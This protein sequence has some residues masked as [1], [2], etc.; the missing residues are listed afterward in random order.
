M[1]NVLQDFLV[2]LGFKID[3]AAQKKM[4]TALETLQK[5]AAEATI[6]LERMAV[7]LATSVVA[8]EVFTGL[9]RMAR[10]F[11]DLAYSAKRTGSS[12]GDV[13]AFAYAVSQLGGT[14][15]GAM[16]SM[17]GLARRVRENPGYAA[18]LKNLGVSDP[19]NTERS[20][21]ELGRKFADLQK[22]GEYF[23]AAQYAND[24]GFDEQTL[25]AM[26]AG[27][28]QMADE[29]RAKMKAAGLDPEKAKEDGQKL[30]QVF[31]SMF[32]SID[33]IFESAGSKIFEKLGGP[34]KD[35]TAFLD[36]NGGRISEVIVKI[37]EAILGLV[38]HISKFIASDE[39][40]KFVDALTDPEKWDGFLKKLTLVGDMF[41]KILTVLS[42]ISE[43][44]SW[45]KQAEEWVR[46]RAWGPGGLTSLP[47]GY[48]AGDGVH[49]SLAGRVWNR[50]K[51]A[52]NWAT[53]GGGGEASGGRAGKA[54]KSANAAAVMD[55]LK[56]A[57]LP[58]EG[59]AAAMGSAQSESAFNPRA[60]NSVSGGHDGLIQWDST[61]WPKVAAWIKSQGGDPFDA[62]W[63]ARAFVAEG[64]AKPGDPLYDGRATARG[65]A[66]LENSA[67]HL[68]MAVL[69]MGLI[70][71]F[72]PREEGGRAANARAWLPHVTAPAA[73]P[74]SP[75]PGLASG[76]PGDADW[77][78]HRGGNVPIPKM[79]ILPPAWAG[80][81]D[82][83]SI[84]QGFAPL[85]VGGSPPANN[86]TTAHQ[87]VSITVHGSTDPDK[88]GEMIGSHVKRANG[89]LL[90]TM[91]SP[92][93]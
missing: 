40:K 5:R 27:V 41:D 15:Q 57:G 81:F 4:H 42:K 54:S 55:E 8:K 90:S 91:Q 32:T 6:A 10:G 88:T 23:R 24:L 84:R 75:S 30:S 70:E 13:R 56:K 28:G 34:L 64:R 60:H 50:A 18:Y 51:K 44:L 69:G 80:K 19:R 78:N 59:I 2:R 87:N 86:N 45:E 25:Q 33:V 9:E 67:G 1:E 76:N 71:R 7:A 52:W 53:G 93:Q 3:D 39:G 92:V 66:M 31:R 89:D 74:A 21:E 72:G 85:G 20:M 14:A 22:R 82:P 35:F 58:P 73:A 49:E 68:G 65:F 26:I 37:A 61:R 48:L 79:A 77:Q 36:T 83:D 47:G 46:D 29:H 62:R 38:T 12:A 11:E 16:Q 17:E 63:Q 43:L